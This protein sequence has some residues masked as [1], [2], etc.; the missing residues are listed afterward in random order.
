[1]NFFVNSSKRACSKKIKLFV[2]EDRHAKHFYNGLMRQACNKVNECVIDERKYNSMNEILVS[3]IIPSYNREK[4]LLISVNSVLEQTVQNIEVIVVDDGS[5]DNTRKIV[6]SIDDTRVIYVYQENEGAC[7]A[8]NNGIKKARGKY[9]AFQDSDDVWHK[10]KLEKQ[11]SCFKDDSVDIVFCKLNRVNG[12]KYP[13]NIKSGIISPV[14]DVSSIGTQTIIAKRQVFEKYKFDPEMP[15]FQELE[16]LMRA[17]REFTLFC[18]N[19]E[20]VDYYMGEDSISVN[21]IKLFK[22]CRLIQKKDS[23]LL[24]YYPGTCHFLTRELI[25]QAYVLKKQGNSDWLKYIRLAIN[26]DKNIKTIIKIILVL[27]G[28]SPVNPFSATPDCHKKCD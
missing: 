21:P 5:T 1:M 6:E 17:T 25:Y 24:R 11:I 23:S 12:H 16:L 3:V 7:A 8:R 4:T 18:L 10:D 15:R 26:L 19:E 20:L 27:L 22:A 2:N 13:D 9:I 14:T 28:F